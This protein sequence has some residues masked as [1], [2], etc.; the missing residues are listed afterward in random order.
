[1]SNGTSGNAGYRTD[2]Y[3]YPPFG[4]TARTRVSSDRVVSFN[5]EYDRLLHGWQDTRNSKLGGGDVPATPTAPAFSI[6]GITDISFAQH[7]GWGLRA[8]ANYQATRAWSVEPYYLHWS[9][10]ASP[11]NYQTATFTVNRVTAHQQLGAYEPF[12]VTHEF[13][14]KLGLHF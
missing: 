13:G 9:V 4:I 10:D 11:V 3:L 1:L 6:D 5:L 8:S 2:N 14:V 7:G 12:N